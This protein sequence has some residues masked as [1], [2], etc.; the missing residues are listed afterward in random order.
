VEVYV[1]RLGPG[2]ED[3]VQLLAA[4]NTL[5]DEERIEPVTKPPPTDQ[6]ASDL[7]AS[8]DDHLLVAFEG[9]DPIGFVLAHEL[10]RRDG[11]GRRLFV[12]EVGVRYDRRRQG[13]GRRLLEETL[14]IGS[15][16]GIAKAFVITNEANEAATALYRAVG[17][18]PQAPDDVV[19]GFTL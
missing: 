19:F 4:Q 1:R 11:E 18:L 13:V 12:Y 14:R 3:I 16:R 7:L 10:K 2:D 6:S 8:G 17:G 15:D 9:D 5:F